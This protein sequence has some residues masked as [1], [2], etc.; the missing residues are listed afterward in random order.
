MSLKKKFIIL[1]VVMFAVLISGFF[2][3]AFLEYRK[4]SLIYEAETKENSIAIEG[5]LKLKSSSLEG[6]AYD[7]TYW[8][9]MV[10]LINKKDENWA[11]NNLDAS[12]DT[13]DANADW[14]YST[15]L[16]LI[17]SVNNLGSEGALKEIPIDKT[18]VK[19]LFAKNKFCHFFVKTES[20]FMEIYG[21][22]VHPS[23]DHERKTAPRGYFFTGRLWDEDFIKE[24]S[25]FIGVSVKDIAFNTAAE[26]QKI[27]QKF[28]ELKNKTLFSYAF[29]GWDGNTLAFFNITKPLESYLVYT[30][31]IHQN[32]IFIVIASSLFFVGWLCVLLWFFGPLHALS[33]ALAQQN[34]SYINKFRKDIS[35]FGNITRLIFDFFEQRLVLV[36]QIKERQKA[37]EGLKKAY[38]ELKKTQNE[39]VQTEKISALGRFSLGAAHEIK[40]PLAI[41]LSGAEFLES[42]N[43]CSQD[44]D[45]K[46]AVAK[47]KDSVSRADRILQSLLKFARPSELKIETVKP[48]TFINETIF[49]LAYKINQ[50]GIKLVTDF[51]Q[52]SFYIAID[53]NQMQQVILNA[54]FNAMEAMP[55]GGVLNIRVYQLVIPGVFDDKPACV[56]EITDSGMGMSPEVLARVFEPFFTSKR[57]RAGTGLGLSISKSIVKNHSGDL[58]VDSKLGKGTTVKI[59]LPIAKS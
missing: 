58:L 39:L 49:M 36:N 24:I 15:D 3:Q 16:D 42:Q 50:A 48:E 53:K 51:S 6:Y 55:S 45:I 20:G 34:T 10:D 43:K 56:I 59:V 8:D 44:E 32:F 11:K 12:L 54:M 40:N 1:S 38:E 19:Q 9:E 52:G 35:E 2:T 4:A 33:L 57:D 13:Y 22:T 28:N 25:E 29:E 31:L 5:I 23:N 18:S 46:T 27:T 14:V 47:I 17:Y 30:K 37:E 41:I 21:A 7:Y 26:T